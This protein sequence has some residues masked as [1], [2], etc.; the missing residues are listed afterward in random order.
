VGQQSEY[1]VFFSC[2]FSHFVKSPAFNS[3]FPVRTMM[4]AEQVQRVFFSCFFFHLVKSPAL[5]SHFPVR[6]VIFAEQ[7][8]RLVLSPLSH[9]V[10]FCPIPHLGTHFHR[11][12]ACSLQY[13]LTFIVKSHHQYVSPHTRTRP[14]YQYFTLPPVS[15]NLQVIYR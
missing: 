9:S 5:N 1:Q 15:G 14:S 13:I 7:V 3:R 11:T 6:T 2:F 4:F 10:L 12:S 8:Q